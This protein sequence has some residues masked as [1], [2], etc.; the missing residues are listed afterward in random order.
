MP[1]KRSKC[2]AG[3][4]NRWRFVRNAYYYQ[5]PPGKEAFWDG[6]QTFPLGKTLP[7]AYR[8]WATR[9]GYLD[10][11]HTVSQLLERYEA[12]VM[13]E[14]SPKTRSEGVRHSVMLRKVFGNMQLNDIE[15]QHIYQYVDARSKKQTDK[16]GKVTGGRT[17]A[18]REIELLSH[19]FTKAVEWGYIS[20]HPF[21]GEVRLK[22][23]KPRDRYIEDWEIAEALSLP[24][25]TGDST[26]RVIQAYIGLKL[27]TGLR[28]GDML[29]ITMADLK[30]DGIHVTPR[31]TSHHGGKSII[32]SWTPALRDAVETAKALRPIDFSPWLFCT[33]RGECYANDETGESSGWKTAWRRF[34]GR[35]LDETK[36]EERFTEHDLRAKAGS[37]AVSLERAQELLT[38]SDSRITERVYRRKAKI[39]A[40]A[41]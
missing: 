24:V 15:P 16:D 35:L 41:K 28:Q 7:E 22:G 1:R 8:V 29:R 20:R 2:N 38:H 30:D 23:E 37:D 6:K 12:E 26:T 17:I 40:P 13:P 10:K 11:I 21:K 39:I 18:K 34:M 5:V 9:I 33:R 3:L 14:K 25:K 36:I 4:P 19:A 27:L 31:K 32:I